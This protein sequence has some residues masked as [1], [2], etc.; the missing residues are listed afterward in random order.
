MAFMQTPDQNTPV[1]RRPARRKRQ[2]VDPSAATGPD[3]V[4]ALARGLRV[5]RCFGPD[6]RSLGNLELAAMT[7]LPKSTISRLVF[8]LTSLGY[9]RYHP[10]TGQYSPDVGVLA[11]G[12]GLLASLEIRHL[13]RPFME[14]LAQR[15]GGAVALG[16]F[17]GES[18]VYVEAIHGSSALYLRLPVGYRLAM[19]SA[20]GRAHL[21]QL[22]PAQCK[23]LLQSLAAGVPSS[24]QMKK[25]RADYL[26]SGCCFGIGDW[27]QG[28]NAVAVPF[29]P[30]T[31][32]HCFVLSCGGPASLLPEDRLRG[33]VAQQLR[34]IAQCLS[35]GVH[36]S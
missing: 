27:Q 30:P 23:A 2:P 14:D 9:L 25:A 22:P 6:T 20:M 13:A 17:D 33:E 24:A 32:Q 35:P 11:L 8:T 26:A 3:F 7:G 12:Y 36:P 34:R 5:L 16:R 4:E 1:L 28:I 19:D 29:I 21:A 10:D 15:T 18:M 31:E